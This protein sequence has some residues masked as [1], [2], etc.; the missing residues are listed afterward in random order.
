M[1]LSWGGMCFVSPIHPVAPEE[2]ICGKDK[3]VSV[4]NYIMQQGL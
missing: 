3:S 4:G 1:T 2:G